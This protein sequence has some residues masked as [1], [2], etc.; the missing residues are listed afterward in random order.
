MIMLKTLLAAEVLIYALLV[1]ALP[2]N[3]A[4]YSFTT[5]DVPGAG[6]TGTEAFGINNQ[7]QVSGTFF[8]PFSS[9]LEESGFLY[10][11]G[12]FTNIDVPGAILTKAFGINDAGQTVGD[13]SV[14]VSSR[15]VA[16]SP[17]STCPGI[18]VRGSLLI[19]A[20]S[21]MRV[22]LSDLSRLHSPSSTASA[23]LSATRPSSP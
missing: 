23:T 19:H 22:K 11:K 16:T 13:Y 5:I 15:R 12:V 2:A 21:T 6:P 1:A 10:S 17:P 20:G 3:A 4:P 9:N 14:S 7:G 18:T 8:D